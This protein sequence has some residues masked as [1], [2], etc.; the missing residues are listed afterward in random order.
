MT[1]VT[2]KTLTL[3][4]GTTLKIHRDSS[5]QPGGYTV[6]SHDAGKDLSKALEIAGLD[7]QEAGQISGQLRL[8]GV[9]GPCYEPVENSPVRVVLNNGGTITPLLNTMVTKVD[10]LHASQAR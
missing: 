1:D 8:D 6:I 5:A 3:R 2:E 9:A 4:D 10:P 7:D